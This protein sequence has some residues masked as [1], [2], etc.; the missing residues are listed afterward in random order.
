MLEAEILTMA[1]THLCEKFGIDQMHLVIGSIRINQ[2]IIHYHFKHREDNYFIT[3]KE[4]GC[5]IDSYEIRK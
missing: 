4:D 1:K 5:V 2:T 3:I